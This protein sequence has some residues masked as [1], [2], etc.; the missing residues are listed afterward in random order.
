MVESVKLNT[1]IISTDAGVVK[2]R[3]CISKAQLG[4]NTENLIGVLHGSY[5]VFEQF[6]VNRLGNRKTNHYIKTK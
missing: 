3:T 1:P 4:E 6:F 2:Y 5:F